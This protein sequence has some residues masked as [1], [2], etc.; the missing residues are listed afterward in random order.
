MSNQ[1]W[2]VNVFIA[3]FEERSQPLPTVLARL[4]S[5]ITP[6]ESPMGE[7]QQ[8]FLKE[9]EGPLY[10][11]RG[12][13]ESSLNEL[14]T[15]C[16]AHPKAEGPIAIV[17]VISNGADLADTLAL[18]HWLDQH[19]ESFESLKEVR[20]FPCISETTSL[21]ISASLLRHPSTTG[22]L[23]VSSEGEV[24]S[25][26][27]IPLLGTWSA[28][29]DY[30]IAQGTDTLAAFRTERKLSSTLSLSGWIPDL[31]EGARIFFHDG[32]EGNEPLDLIGTAAM[33]FAMEE[34][35]QVST[36]E[37]KFQIQDAT[38]SN[39]SIRDKHH[40]KLI[41][42]I[43]I[44][45]PGADKVQERDAMT[46]GR[47]IQRAF[48]T[49]L[50]KA[51]K[52]PRDN[53][54]HAEVR[55]TLSDMALDS[56]LMG[57]ETYAPGLEAFREDLFDPTEPSKTVLS[58]GTQS[59]VLLN[60]PGLSICFNLAFHEGN[61]KEMVSHALKI[62]LEKATVE[63]IR[64][65]FR[66]Y[67]NQIIGWMQKALASQNLKVKMGIPLAISTDEVVPS[68][69][70]NQ[71]YDAGCVVVTGKFRFEIRASINITDADELKNVRPLDLKKLLTQAEEEI[72]ID[73]LLDSQDSFSK[74]GD[75][76][77]T[78]LAEFRSQNAVPREVTF[79]GWVPEL[80]EGA[81]LHFFNTSDNSPPNDLLGT[82]VMFFAME[83]MGQVD[84]SEYG[85]Q[86]QDSTN[87]L[88]SIREKENG[89]L[90]GL[91]LF[92][93]KGADKISPDS[94]IALGQKLKGSFTVSQAKVVRAAR[95]NDEFA[96][97]RKIVADLSLD[98][99]L[100]RL[101]SYF[102]G[103]QSNRED[104]ADPNEPSRTLIAG[105]TQS[106][107]MLTGQ[108]LS[109]TFNLAFLEGNLKQLVAESLKI[110]VDKASLEVIRDFF[111][112]YLNQVVGWV[113][114]VLGIQN[115]KVKIGIPLALTHDMPLP[116]FVKGLIYDTG[117]I[118]VVGKYRFEI[119]ASINISNGA[120]LKA[121]QPQDVRN[122]VSPKS[123]EVDIEA[124]LDA[125]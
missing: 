33:F 81:K 61:L 19:H 125:L 64:D 98:S 50:P 120:T 56:V 115:V 76:A 57:L 51:I 119:R 37:L 46:L 78:A 103:M 3:S 79:S 2:G 24:H 69:L 80:E 18:L 84:A 75:V 29:P 62:P 23:Y 104:L 110:S 20:V 54:A 106:I 28:P 112:E 65:F 39:I 109:I 31:E 77:A 83:E 90:L 60:G 6:V 71:V 26:H 11:L 86:A 40:G 117:C 70:K 82:A 9:C 101:E 118:L 25:H 16:K 8:L 34:M 68:F 35:G 5:H 121:L 41:G 48:K 94:L 63:V 49:T 67:L 91:L 42:A 92:V 12:S 30:W 99:C 14:L 45:G 107:C 55:K 97:E 59:F 17:P 21:Q 22:I 123:E 96:R 52:P 4:E 100:L 10:D 53:D 102:A 38:N 15:R 89:K 73:A 13:L 43:L 116:S 95:T 27:N 1:S 108:D 7:I 85:Y 74:A 113:Q 114:K 47:A 93:G 105:G 87:V 66:E 124:L 122:A 111:R 88:V 44:S 58:G 36:D 72:D 32:G